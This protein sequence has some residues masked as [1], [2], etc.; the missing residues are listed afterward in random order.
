MSMISSVSAPVEVGRMDPGLGVNLY[1]SMRS[2]DLQNRPK[3]G[4]EL[5]HL[6]DITEYV[7]ITFLLFTS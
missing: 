5:T 2:Q 3:P 4:C 6:T 7:L 1:G